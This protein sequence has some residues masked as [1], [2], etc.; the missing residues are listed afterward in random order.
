MHEDRH[1]SALS[2]YEKSIYPLMI[3][4]ADVTLH[5]FQGLICNYFLGDAPHQSPWKL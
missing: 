1:F 4:D 2:I 5:N 3:N